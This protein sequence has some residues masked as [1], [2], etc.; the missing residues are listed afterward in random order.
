MSP[1]HPA[2][3]AM[4]VCDLLM[5]DERTHKVSLIGITEHIHAQQFPLTVQALFVYATITDGQGDYRIRLDLVRLE[6]LTSSEILAEANITLHDR[7]SVGELSFDLDG[8]AFERPGR[9]ELALFANDRLVGAKSLTVIQSIG[10]R[11]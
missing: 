1:V 2:I 8:F 4:L 6:D 7:N 11:E 5:R 10:E 9:Y 3:R